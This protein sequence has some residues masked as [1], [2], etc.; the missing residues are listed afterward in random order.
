MGDRALRTFLKLIGI[1]V[2]YGAVWVWMGAGGLTLML[3]TVFGNFVNV[4]GISHSFGEIGLGLIVV[5]GGLSAV[6]MV[7]EIGTHTFRTGRPPEMMDFHCFRIFGLF[8][9]GA[10]FAVFCLLPP[11]VV[12]GLLGRNTPKAL[13]AVASAAVPLFIII[14]LIQGLIERWR[15]RTSGRGIDSTRQYHR[16]TGKW[17][18]DDQGH[19]Q[20]ADISDEGHLAST[21]PRDAMHA[22][23]KIMPNRGE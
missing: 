13:I 5:V 6:L 2:A 4:C 22:L 12:C 16:R 21:P 15:Y 10:M 9:G 1:T 11:F 8:F 17:V 14:V 19:W 18:L 7:V 3:W 23:R 20:W